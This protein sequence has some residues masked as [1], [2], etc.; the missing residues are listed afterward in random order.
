MMGREAKYTSFQTDQSS[1]FPEIVSFPDHTDE[2][3]PPPMAESCDKQMLIISC[4]SCYFRV[5]SK[6]LILSTVSNCKLISRQKL[7]ILEGWMC[8]SFSHCNGIRR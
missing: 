5:I 6:K 2:D 3:L 8:L 4:C 7:C 1:S